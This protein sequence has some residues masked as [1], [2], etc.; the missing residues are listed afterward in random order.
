MLDAVSC[1]CC[2]SAVA[3]ITGL[4]R[5][6][7]PSGMV[8]QVAKI[9]AAGRDIAATADIDLETSTAAEVCGVRQTLGFAMVGSL[10]RKQG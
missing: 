4:L 1:H 9:L 6:A 10:S 3:A 7:S 8:H 5:S 2:H